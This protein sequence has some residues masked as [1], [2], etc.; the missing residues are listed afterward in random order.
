MDLRDTWE[1]LVDK[2]VKV[3]RESRQ[4]EVSQENKLLHLYTEGH[5]AQRIKETIYFN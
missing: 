5:M 1:V 4:R 3:D 2:G